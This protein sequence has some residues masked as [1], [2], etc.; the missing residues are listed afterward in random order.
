MAIIVENTN[1]NNVAGFTYPDIQNEIIEIMANL[2]KNA[3]V[4]QVMQADVIIS[5]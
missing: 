1:N 3:I 2:T 5:A 4:E